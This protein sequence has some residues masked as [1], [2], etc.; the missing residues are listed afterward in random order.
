MP[1]DLKI[2]AQH[3]Y[4]ILTLKLTESCLTGKKNLSKA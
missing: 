4:N 2:K 3:S 1:D